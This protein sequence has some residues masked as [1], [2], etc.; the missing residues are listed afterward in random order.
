M[1]NL[2]FLLILIFTNILIAV[3][4]SKMRR[5]KNVGLE[6]LFE[7]SFLY[8]HDLIYLNWSKLHSNNLTD[9]VSAY[10]ICA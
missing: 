4:Q 6:Q 8:L 5:I 10:S 9:Y 3:E 2:I 1:L 7:N